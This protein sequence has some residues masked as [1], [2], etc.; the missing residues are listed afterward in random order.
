MKTILTLIL[1]GMVGL[2]S[3]GNS[4]SEPKKNYDDLWK[5][6]AESI[7]KN[8][9]ESATQTLDSIEQKAL[10]DNNQTQ[11]LKSWINRQQIFRF[12]VEDDPQQEYIRYLESKVGQ[13]DVVHEALLHEEIAQTYANYLDNHGRL[14]YNPPIEGDLSKVEMKYWDSKSLRSRI[15]AHFAEA[16][17]PVGDL[18]KAETKDFMILF[19][20]PPKNVED[21]LEYE[22]TVYEYLFHRAAEYYQSRANRNCWTAMSGGLPPRIL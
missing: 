22:K 6:Y 14:Y 16:L 12:T 21:Y 13:S 9:P 5:S 18:K 17:K 8:L 20:N 7:N 11:L 3:A 1:C 10:K 4:S 19:D 2:V 15:D